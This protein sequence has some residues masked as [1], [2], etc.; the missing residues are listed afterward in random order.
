M[1]ITNVSCEQ[2][3]GVR[4]LDIPLKDGINVIYG[5][6]ESGKSTL[7][8]LISRTFFQSVKKDERTEK[9]KAFKSFFTVPKRGSSVNIDSIDGKITFETEK[10]TYTLIKE[11][12]ADRRC[13][14]K[15]P[16]GV[17][18]DNESVENVLKE[19]MSYGE[20]VYANMLLSSQKNADASL[21]TILDS[22]RSN[23]TKS[24]IVDAVSKAFIESAG[25]S[26]DAVEQAIQTKIDDI[27]G[28][29][30]DFEHEA[31]EKNKRWG[32]DKGEIL[33]AYYALEDANAVF[34][35]IYELEDNVA[36][37]TEDYDKQEEAF[38]AA[39][40]KLSRFQTYKSLLTA[41][42][43]ERENIDRLKNDIAKA[44]DVLSK[45]PSMVSDLEK[46]DALKRELEDRET[47]DIYSAAKVSQDMIMEGKKNLSSMLCPEEKE[48]LEVDRAERC[49]MKLASMLRGM[50]L[51]ATVRMLGGNHIEIRSI[52]TGEE[53]PVS[54]T[55]AITEAVRL[56]IPDVMEMELAPA[57]VNVA[58]IKAQMDAQRSTINSIFT[59]YKVQS[60]EELEKLRRDAEQIQKK[61]SYAESELKT[62]LGRF[63]F[64]EEA[65]TAVKK[66]SSMPRDKEKI[67]A[68]IKTVCG[69]KKIDIFMAAVENSVEIYKRDYT[70]I[71]E[72]N[73]KIL[74]L[75][76]ALNKAE[77]KASSAQDIPE[78]FNSIT[79]PEAHLHTLEDAYGMAKKSWQTA[80]EAKTSAKGDLNAKNDSLTSDPIDDLEKAERDFCEKKALLKHWLHIREVFE[81]EK[82]KIRDNP[83]VDLAENFALCLDIITDGRV[84]SEFPEANKLNMKLY[85]AD[86]LVDY[87]KL[88]EG[89]KET[90][91]LAFR[92][93]VLDH[94]F[95]EGG[96]ITVLDDPF[97]NM[98]AE[99]TAQAVELIKDC[100]KRHQVI[101]LTCKEEY[102][103][104]LGG[105]FIE[106]ES[107]KM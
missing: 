107:Q 57:N 106:I 24:E 60:L 2:F 70:G 18:R 98:D 13:T 74:A 68:D 14:L 89:T 17:L 38:R 61:I 87:G 76:T 100:A 69:P 43:D 30:W 23:E 5:K 6:N 33:E 90:V 31:P 88:S 58:D 40:E 59:K 49:E 103:S 67:E 51:N 22:S 91:S 26:V 55:V 72:L 41:R 54:D 42:S 66:I 77:E 80:L 65:E 84:V 20:G 53:I 36:K 7:V 12:G 83:F 104:M 105:N 39:E 19:A 46:A 79:D 29:H 11:W 37:A 97:A 47:Y 78:E 50:N 96:G 62:R 35:A 64:F 92:M 95:P 48:L 82:E 101:F 75:Q 16:D 52:R 85:S 81:K 34:E 8:N 63:T 56:T 44:K 21:Q 94:L 4:D 93:A 28:K 86:R 9:G 27:A 102:R 25:V 1:K 73:A 15:A 32:R 3:A 45:W 71:P 99:R 10:G